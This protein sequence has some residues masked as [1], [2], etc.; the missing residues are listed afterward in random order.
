MKRILVPCDFTKPALQ[1]YKFATDLAA[2]SNGEVFVLKVISVPVM[3]ESTFGIQPYLFNPSIV[4]DLE[5]KAEKNFKKLSTIFPTGNLPVNFMIDQGSVIQE[6]N[7]FINSKNIDLVVMGTH[8]AS[9]LKEVFIGS[10]TE[11]IVRSSTVPVIAIRK[12]P[13]ISD[14]K[15]IVYPCALDLKHD[16]LIEKIKE[17]Q[18]IFGAT[19]H[20]LFINT[21]EN[22]R[23]D[24]EVRVTLEAYAQASGIKNYTIN[25]HNDLNERDGIISFTNE[26]NANLIVMAT[27]GRKGLLH[28]FAGSIAEDVVNHVTCPIWTFAVRKEQAETVLA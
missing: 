7:T 17:L 25:I 20:L 5:E 9:G 23:R 1:A 26:I 12:A 15:N 4:S 11:K 3:Y 18:N 28:L 16:Q 22:F 6:I 24:N 19:V 13:E 14:I 10:N 21:P 2:V 8:G 27:H